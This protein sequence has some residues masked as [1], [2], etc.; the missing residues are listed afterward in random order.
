MSRTQLVMLVLIALV[1]AVIIGA[2]PLAKHAGWLVETEESLDLGPTV[3]AR[4]RPLLAFEKML[5]KLGQPA[6]RIETLV[7]LPPLDHLI[8]IGGSDWQI[9][10][11]AASALLDWVQRGGRLI[12]VV[13][14]DVASGSGVS[15]VLTTLGIAVGVPDDE[16]V[17][18]CHKLIPPWSHDLFEFCL[19][20]Q[21]PITIDPRPVGSW[22][23]EDDHGV[24]LAVFAH[25]RGQVSV[26]ADPQ[27]FDNKTIDEL[28]S[29]EI[30][31]ELVRLG[32][33]PR[34][35]WFLTRAAIPPLGEWLLRRGWPLLLS[36]F[37]WLA[38]WC[39]YRAARFGPLLPGPK[40][41]RRSIAEQI[42][43]VGRWR[44]RR[45]DLMTLIEASRAAVRRRALS[46]HP[47][48]SKLQ[49][50]EFA[51]RLAAACALEVSG[52]ARAL[53]EPVTQL[54][55]FTQAMRTLERARRTV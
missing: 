40:A 31:W 13:P 47:E 29:A 4:T 41:V 42:E 23:V 53:Q 51:D 46:R 16:H 8:V 34:S 49:P 38:A 24:Y 3:E 18:S 28:Q 19:P 17:T 10:R 35:V 20:A 44:W 15:A 12:L 14:S 48:W 43:H 11:P 55:E 22:M 7:P 1:V 33:A 50:A 5:V 37:V 45:R 39:W 2:F 26:L 32:G 6:Q 25:G 9:P 27:S 52:V 21:R 54:T 36:V 30:G